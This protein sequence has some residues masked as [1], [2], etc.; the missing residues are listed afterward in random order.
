VL[1]VTVAMMRKGDKLESYRMLAGALG[2]ITDNNWR[3]ILIGDGECRKEIEEMFEN[4]TGH[5]LFTGELEAEKI[6]GWLGTADI[7][8]WPSVNE[9]YGL[10][11]LEAVA[12]GL[13]AVVYDYGGVGQIIEHDYNGLVI[14][15]GDRAGYACALE[16]MISNPGLRKRYASNS[17]RKFL[18]D[19]TFAEAQRRVDSIVDAVVFGQ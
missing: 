7:Y 2:N 16:A 11:L 4:V 15:P 13:P 19:H 1:L 3:L 18:R 12:Y 14:N 5:C 9:A 17:N 10:A 8:A 6:A